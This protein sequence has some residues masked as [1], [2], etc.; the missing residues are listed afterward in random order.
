MVPPH[1]WA[2]LNLSIDMNNPLN[3]P[4]CMA[5]VHVNFGVNLWKNRATCDMGLALEALFLA[6][7]RHT[8]EFFCKIRHFD[9]ISPP[10]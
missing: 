7:S 1:D 4:A 3:I 6:V 8:L 10:N 5:R 2:M 9:E